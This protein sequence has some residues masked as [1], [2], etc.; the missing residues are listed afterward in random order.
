MTELTIIIPTLN[1]GMSIRTTINAV[2]DVVT[3]AKIDAEILVVDDNSTDDTHEVMRDIMAVHPNVH[4][5]VRLTDHGLSNSLADGFFYAAS[6]VLMVMDSDGQHPPSLI[7]QLFQ[8]I[9]DGYD[10][11]VA[12]RYAKGGGIWYSPWYRRLLSWGATYLARFF[13]PDIADSGSGFFAFKREVI[14][15]APLQPQGFRML[16]E[17]LGKGKWNRAIEIP[18]TLQVR[19][20]GQSKLKATTILSYLKQ[21]WG[22]FKYSI[23]TKESHGHAEIKRVVSYM[24]VGFSG[25]IISLSLTYI[26]AGIYNMWYMWAATIA[27][28]TSILTN[29]TLNDIITFGDVGSKL[30]IASRLGLYHLVSIGGMAITLAATYV[31]TEWFNMWYVLSI[32]VGIML[33]FIWNF[34]VNRNITW[35]E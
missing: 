13:F 29:F 14:Q 11:A 1:E 5:L 30:D 2:I 6:P 22:L 26:L 4:M 10:V 19:K 28:E 3:A 27:V 31:C 33:A 25:S 32:T 18:Y 7:P 12:S 15:N 9:Y 20:E 21:V 35:G 24:L 17:V 8:E 23:T 16:F 34:T